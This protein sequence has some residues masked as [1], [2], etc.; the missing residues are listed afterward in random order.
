MIQMQ[1]D[2]AAN[3]GAGDVRLD[4]EHRGSSD[5]R[6]WSQLLSDRYSIT[7]PHAAVVLLHLRRG[8]GDD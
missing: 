5:F 1:S 4:G 6:C 2:P 3:D 7:L 8:G